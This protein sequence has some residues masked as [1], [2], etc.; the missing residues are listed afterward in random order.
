ML[1]NGN[2]CI[3]LR[4]WDEGMAAKAAGSP[5]GSFVSFDGPVSNLEV[6]LLA[7]LRSLRGGRGISLDAATTGLLWDC[8]MTWRMNFDE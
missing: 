2:Q 1:M 4:M 7:Y 3:G 6:N 8:F 5:A